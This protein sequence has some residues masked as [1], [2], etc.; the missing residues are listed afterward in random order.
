LDLDRNE[1]TVDVIEERAK[2]GEA[3]EN[4]EAEVSRSLYVT[5][6][7]L[8]PSCRRIPWQGSGTRKIRDGIGHKGQSLIVV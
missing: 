8:I 2:V 1:Q 3:V 4:E 7:M 6:K 5:S